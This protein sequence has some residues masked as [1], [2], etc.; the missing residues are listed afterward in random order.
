MGVDAFLRSRGFSLP[1]QRCEENDGYMSLAQKEQ[2]SEQLSLYPKIRRIAEIGFNGG[3]SA[4]NFFER[5]PNLELLIAFDLNAYTCTRFAAEYFYKTYVDRFALILGD[6]LVTVTEFHL[7]NPNLLFDLIYIDGC[8]DFEWVL[9]DIMNAQ[10]IA[11]NQT[12]VWLDDVKEQNEVA[13][14]IKFLESTG[15]IHI[16]QSFASIDPVFGPRNWIQARFRAI[17]P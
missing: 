15:I 7:Q 9:G 3:H 6:S 17:F 5:C 1:A 13:A 11:H 12:I 10:K 4:E 16:E 14:A 8:H 2:F